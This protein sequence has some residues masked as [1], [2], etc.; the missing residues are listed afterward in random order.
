M[1]IELNYWYG[2]VIVG[3]A[4]VIMSIS[5]ESKFYYPLIYFTIGLIAIRIFFMIKMLIKNKK[6]KK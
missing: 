5:K 3:F 4:L 2:L 6:H 1:K